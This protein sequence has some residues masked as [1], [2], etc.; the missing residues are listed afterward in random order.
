MRADIRRLALA[1]LIAIVAGLIVYAG[2]PADRIK[3]ELRADAK[4]F[5]LSL[6]YSAKLLKGRF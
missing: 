3:A 6:E 4:G 5:V 1:T 2:N